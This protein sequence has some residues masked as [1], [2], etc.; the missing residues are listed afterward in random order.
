MPSEPTSID[1][2]EF[3]QFRKIDRDAALTRLETE[4]GSEGVIDV[5]YVMYNIVRIVVLIPHM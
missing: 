5:G 1:V 3:C 2:E 4:L